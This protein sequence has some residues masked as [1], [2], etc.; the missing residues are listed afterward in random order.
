[1]TL[2]HISIG[3][4]KL[5]IMTEDYVMEL[6]KRV[7]P[8]SVPIY[9]YGIQAFLES[10]DIELNWKKIKRLY[11]AKVKVS[12]AKDYTT[13]QI[14]E[15]LSVT[16][17][18]R[19]KAVIHFLAASG[20]RVGSLPELEMRHLSNISLGCKSVLIYEGSTEEYTA[21]LTPEASKVLEDYF[22]QRIHDREE[23][24]PDSPIFRE[25]Y[26]LGSRPAKP[27][28]RKAIINMMERVVKNAG[29]RGSKNGKRYDIQLDHGFKK[30]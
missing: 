20:C 19:N 10:N 21:F 1:M 13:E 30:C 22:E 14:Q 24:R 26:K 23:L 11:P 15:R 25:D 9:L 7:N 18:Y 17:S 29:V 27:M 12:D 28:S 8:N 5:Q 3:R 16:P 4:D 6:K 2:T